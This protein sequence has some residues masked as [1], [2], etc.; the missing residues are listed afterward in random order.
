MQNDKPETIASLTILVQELKRSY[1]Q[2]S[3]YH[4]CKT[5]LVPFHVWLAT[6]STC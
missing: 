2:V 3:S 1:G 4:C 6:S 5:S